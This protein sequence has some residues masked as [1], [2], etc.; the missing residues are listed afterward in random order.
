MKPEDVRATI[1]KAVLKSGQSIPQIAR[2]SDISPSTLLNYLKGD[3]DMGL[4]NLIKV[5]RTLKIS[6]KL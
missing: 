1:K 5:L 4:S 3:S 2:E 6:I